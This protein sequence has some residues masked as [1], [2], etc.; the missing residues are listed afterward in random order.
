[1][2]KINVR[3]PYFINLSTTNLTSATLEIQIY[4]GAVNTSWQSSPQYTLT[5]TAVGA[6]VNFE[7]AELIKDYI[8]AAFNGTY[9]NSSTAS[10]DDYTT[11]YVDYKTTETLSV[12]SPV[13]TEVLG[14]RAFYGYGYFED[15]VNPQLLQGYLQ[16]NTT[17]LKSDDDALRIP[18]DNENTTS[19]AF[20]YNNEQI[21]SWT[22][23]VNLKIQDQIQYVST[24]SA[25]V[26]NYRERVEASGGTFEDNACIQSFLRN[27][28]IYPV[29]E[30]IIDG[31]EGITVLRVENIQE[32]KY[33]PYKLTFINKFGVY[34]DIYF[35]K[36]SKLAMSTNEEMYKSNILT[37][38]TYNTYDAQKKL[39]TKNG[40]Q[41]L[42]LNSGYYPESNNEV[43]RQLF[44]SEKVW[45]EYKSKTLGVTIE[46]KNIDYKTSLTDS[47]INYTVDLSFAFDTINN[48]R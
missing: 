15:G 17:I 38:G 33:T 23:G 6:K 28:T 36:N 31:V 40:N 20:F 19:V 30:V 24:A 22:P 13:V 32:C 42:T 16:S 1:M 18:I 46:S 10:D 34:Q 47:L 11:V 7:I 3:S 29:D 12:G 27:E 26:D 2:A 21:Y 41:R 44:L 35:F 5:S 37:N 48:I 43:F 39:L 45:I 8:P 14:V 9:P 4:I 25:D